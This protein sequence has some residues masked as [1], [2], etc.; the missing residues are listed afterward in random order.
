MKN[1]SFTIL[2]LA[3]VSFFHEVASTSTRAKKALALAKQGYNDA[4][5][6]LNGIEG[7]QVSPTQPLGQ[8]GQGGA[9]FLATSGQQTRQQ[10]Q[11]QQQQ[12]Q[13]SAQIVMRFSDAVEKNSQALVALEGEQEQLSRQEA[14]FE[15]K[16]LAEQRRSTEEHS[17]NT[18]GG[19]WLQVASRGKKCKEW[20]GG[21]V[22]DEKSCRRACENVKDKDGNTVQWEGKPGKGTCSC[23]LKTEGDETEEKYKEIC[24][25]NSGAGLS[26]S[27]ASALGLIVMLIQ[28]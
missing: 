7:S 20:K 5:E 12:L 6:F 3:G 23:K 18:G 15:A 19:I 22:K 28:M 2:L 27:L 14:A 8:P 25:D 4:E 11:L 1:I 21:A 16:V 26:L 17:H 24:N 13:Q 9:S 10:Q